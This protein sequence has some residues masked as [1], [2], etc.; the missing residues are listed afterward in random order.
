M[1]FNF[2]NSSSI[3]QRIIGYFVAI[4]FVAV[5]LIVIVTVTK[6]KNVLGVVQRDNAKIVT[7]NLSVA[8]GDPMM[9]IAYADPMMA[10]ETDRIT[11]ILMGVKNSDENVEYI[12]LLS[13]DGKCV[14]SSKDQYKDK[15]LNQ[16]DFERNAIAAKDFEIHDNPSLQNVFEAVIPVF[17]ASQR[18]G[19]LRI[20]YTTKNMDALVRNVAFII[21]FIGILVLVGGGIVYYVMIE[22]GIVNPLNRVIE[23]A[24]MIA[25]GNL[26][27]K[28]IV[29]TSNDEIGRLAEIFNKML[30][31]LG[32]LVPMLSLPQ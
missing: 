9:S 3:K 12:I 21:V 5:L 11:K 2:S 17:A 7:T 19:T 23:T 25:D 27:Q 28:Q 16:T 8:C 14:A 4:M 6:T 31:G 30:T 15:Y 13:N 20:G 10:G 18:M 29:V 32:E 22:K 1:F 24:Q 26:S